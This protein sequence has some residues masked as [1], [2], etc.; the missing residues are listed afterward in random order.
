[1]PRSSS[2]VAVI[3]SLLFA[4]PAVVWAQSS[5]SDLVP[6]NASQ[7]A[8]CSAFA[9]QT[10]SNLTF[11]QRNCYFALQLLAPMNA[12]SIVTVSLVEQLRNSPVEN[13]DDWSMLPHRLET[14]YARQSA[15]DA[16]EMLVGY[17]HHEDP[18]P[19]KSTETNFLRRTNAAVMS[20]LTSPGEDGHL[21]PA[22]APLAGSFSSAFAGSAM[23]FRKDVTLSSTMLNAG[24]VYSFY[25]VRA[26][27]AEFKPEMDSLIHHVLHQ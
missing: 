22:L 3:S 10:T 18:R 16:A 24:A 20:V 6:S 19:R 15:R 17:L 21:R 7:N 23:S 11:K 5:S 2:A 13:H 4:L 27:F 8:S 26:V 12:V 14:H 1:L 25:F 9:L